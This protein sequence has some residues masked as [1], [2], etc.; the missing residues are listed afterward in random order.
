[1]N[2]LIIKSIVLT[3]L[4][5]LVAGSFT[6]ISISE[7]NN[8]LDFFPTAEDYYTWKDE[9]NSQQKIDESLSENFELSNGK[10]QIYGTYPQWKDPSFTRMKKITLNSNAARSD[11]PVKLTVDYDSDMRSDY[12][13]LRFQFD[14]ENYF[15][16]YWI[17][18][19]NPDPNDHYAIV[20]IK[21]PSLPSGNSYVYMFYG[22]PSASYQGNYWDVFDENSWSKKYTHDH[23]VT[24]KMASEGAWDPDVC[25]GGSKFLVTWEE[26]IPYWP[27]KGLLN[28]KQQIRG[29]FYDSNGNRQGSRFDITPWT[30]GWGNPFRNENPSNAYGGGKYLVAYE[31][32]TNPTNN[33][34]LDRDIKGAIVTSSGSVSDFTI[35][36]ATNIQADPCV[37]YDSDHSKFLVVWEDGRSGTNNYDIYGRFFSTSGSPIGSEIA[38]VQRSNVQ[39][40]PWVVYDKINDH[41]MIVWEESSSDPENGPFDIWGQLF[42]HQ[43]NDLGNA[44]RLSPTGGSDDYNFPCVAFQEGTE[45]FLVTWQEDDISAGDWYGHIYGVLLDENANVDVPTFKIAHG[46]FER[47]DV[48]DH[49]STQFFVAYDSYGGDIYGKLVNSDGSV[50]YYE[51]QLSDSESDPAD[52]CNIASSGN[53]IF[54]AWEDTRVEYLDQP[55]YDALD[56]PDVF[57]NLWAFNT[58]SGSDVTVSFSEEKSIILS[59]HITSVKIEPANLKTWYMFDAVK[60]GAVSF[61][62]LDGENP[63]TV[64]KSNVAPGANINSVQAESIRLKASF[65]RDNPSS[66]PTLSEWEVQYVGQDTVPPRTTLDNIDGTKGLNEWYTSESVIIWLH[67]EDYPVDTGSGVDKTYYTINGGNTMEYNVGS[68]ILV[69][70]TQ[71]LNWVGYFEIQYWSVD[72]QG[73]Y[74]SDEKEENHLLIKIDAEPP[75]CEL[76]EPADEQQVEVPF[77]VRADATDNAGIARVEFDIEP[78][79]ERDGLP[80]E[81]TTYPYEWYCEEDEPPEDDD[82]IAKSKTLFRTGVNVMVRAQAFDESGQSWLHEVWI[83][84]D[85]WNKTVKD[86]SLLQDILELLNYL[87]LGIKM[88]PVLDVESEVE[89]DSDK[90]VFTAQRIIFRK[91]FTETDNDLSD[92]AATSFK[93]PTGF[94][95]ITCD[96]YKNNNIVSSKLISRSIFIKG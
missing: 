53:K 87:K 84:V 61:D 26:G 72:N 40:E 24:Y 81:D 71:E 36:S 31:H 41:F 38:F 90:A 64:L 17:E 63:S 10:V 20:W 93:I 49:L 42:D 18:S 15:L 2:K 22:K 77:W 29:C 86:D 30:E 6:N 73:N 8:K 23:Q 4:I 19:R 82:P 76:V 94:Y 69:T 91:K 74:E 34:A 92:G 37:V 78:F 70:T 14:N 43:G 13:D 27:A 47:T 60:S 52:W 45:Q 66:S 1:M 5:L 68:G 65:S 46:E 54:V 67:A 89:Q 25:Y 28:F 79:G 83:Y 55:Q 7:K 95:K 50:N 58:P 16:D 21:I 3:L 33:N 44:K 59:A 80:F 96:E 62:I 51:L 32:Y 9:F 48:V 57:G 75:F 39:C 12:G 11:C 56:F 85:N 88:G 35:C